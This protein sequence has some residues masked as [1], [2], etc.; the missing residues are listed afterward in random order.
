M[1]VGVGVGVGRTWYGY[2]GE[3]S[4][5]DGCQAGPEARLIAF[6]VAVAMGSRATSKSD[7]CVTSTPPR[8][9][10]EE[11]SGTGVGVERRACH[12]GD[13]GEENPPAR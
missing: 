6:S 5:G 13:P 9:G 11:M 12:D 7:D 1:G 10:E 3:I 2:G 4:S 8:R